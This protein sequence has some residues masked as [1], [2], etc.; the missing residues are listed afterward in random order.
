VLKNN[1]VKRLKALLTAAVCLL[2]AVGAAACGGQEAEVWDNELTLKTTY[3]TLTVERGADIS[4]FRD[5]AFTLE[6]AKGET[7]GAQVI[8]R[9]QKE[10]KRYT[11]ELPDLVGP[12]GAKITQDR[13]TLY[14]QIYAEVINGTPLFPAGWYPD[15]LIPLRY[16]AAKDENKVAAGQNQGLWLDINVPTDAAAGEYSGRVKL[17]VDGKVFEIPVE[18][19]VFGFERPAVSSLQSS[20]LIWP[21]WLMQGELDATVS[22]WKDY[23]DFLLEYNLVGYDL[24]V[25]GADIE[26]YKAAVREYYPKVAN[27]FIP[28]TYVLTFSIDYEMM[29]RHLL[30]IAEISLED[31]IDYFDKA[32]FYIHTIYDECTHDSVRAT[33]YPATLEV[34]RG[35]AA[36]EERVIDALFDAGKISD[37]NGELASSLRAVRHVMTVQYEE[38]LDKDYGVGNFTPGYYCFQT[39]DNIAFYQSLMERG[40]EIFSYD[41]AKRGLT[42]SFLINDFTISGRDI[43]WSKNKYGVTGDLFWNV[44]AYKAYWQFVGLDYG[45]INYLYRQASH[46]GMT[47]GD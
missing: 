35:V 12:G 11:A 30:A 32:K 44:N 27:F 37:K 47:N 13:L 1:I 10:I 28:F 40:I 39:T 7:E 25:D 33:R 18:L 22:K 29:Y 14:V 5:A 9:P 8:F 42:G 19:T 4:G 15:A 17:D 6:A 3:N 23:F 38:E 26:G 46:D 43:M 21:G 31:E 45:L 2:P 24:P 20:Y 36:A 41:A 16:I 34:L